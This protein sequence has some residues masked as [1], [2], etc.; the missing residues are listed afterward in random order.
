MIELSRI[1]K[2]GLTSILHYSQVIHAFIV[3]TTSNQK[4]ESKCF[5]YIKDQM[6]GLSKAG[7]LESATQEL[8]SYT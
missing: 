7:A 8:I 1:E 5:H 2:E 3:T 6:S 4:T